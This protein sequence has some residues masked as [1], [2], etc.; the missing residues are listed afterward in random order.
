[1]PARV[2]GNGNMWMTETSGSRLSRV[3]KGVLTFMLLFYVYLALTHPYGAAGDTGRGARPR[4]AGAAFE[5]GREGACGR[6]CRG[7]STIVIVLHGRRGE[8]ESKPSRCPVL[9]DL[10][11][12]I[13][14]YS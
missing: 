7:P 8:V 2:V 12:I 10:E 9:A 6:D 5:R 4:D 3:L 14:A 1:M 13:A 11:D